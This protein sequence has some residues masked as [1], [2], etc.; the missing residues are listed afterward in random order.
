MHAITPTHLWSNLMKEHPKARVI[1][2]SFL[3]HVTLKISECLCIVDWF[4]CLWLF[5]THYRD[6]P[7]SHCKWNNVWNKQGE[8]ISLVVQ[9][10]KIHLPMQR[11]GVWSCPL[12]SGKIPH[13]E[14]QQSPC[15][16][17]TEPMLWSRG[18]TAGETSTLRSPHTK[19]TRRPITA[20]RKT[21]ESNK[22]PV[23][24]KIIVN[25]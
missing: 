22:G 25:K 19:R 11:T 9:W 13:A 8:W 14:E 12:W 3:N 2:F 21:S 6:D 7:T 18:A 23:Q 16:R 24:P 15:P 20:T 10:L 17:T 4:L 1:F 5:L